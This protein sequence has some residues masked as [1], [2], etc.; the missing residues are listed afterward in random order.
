MTDREQPT[1]DLVAVF[2][3]TDE[4][5]A[6][7]ARSILEEAG[8]DCAVKGGLMNDATGIS[9]LGTMFAPG[10]RPVEV[11]VLASQAE[12]AALLLKEPGFPPGSGEVLL[13]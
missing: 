13:P 10:I 11:F 9:R 4:T 5:A 3:S 2:S 1:E 12:E 8:I 7:V 6:A